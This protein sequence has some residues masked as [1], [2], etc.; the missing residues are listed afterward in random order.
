MYII[1]FLLIK[2][3][4]KPKIKQQKR[5]A[6][7]SR[8]NE[9]TKNNILYPDRQRGIKNKC[10]YLV[11]AHTTYTYSVSC[12]V[13]CDVV[14]VG[15]SCAFCLFTNAVAGAK[16][17]ITRF[18]YHHWTNHYWCHIITSISPAHKSPN[19]KKKKYGVFWGLGVL[20]PNIVAWWNCIDLKQKK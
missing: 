6:N 4:E 10:A 1:C 17:V 12:F 15:F 5:L 8:N 14:T 20:I 3:H 18:F 7:C 11:L 19:N 2:P 9:R 13:W 16:A